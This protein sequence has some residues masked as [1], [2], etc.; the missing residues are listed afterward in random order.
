MG[1]SASI[2]T[3]CH[4]HRGTPLSI[5]EGDQLT[6]L[7]QWH[8]GRPVDGRRVDGSP[9]P[10]EA[11]LA[12]IAPV[13]AET[14]IIGGHQPVR[15]QR[16]DQLVEGGG[17]EIGPVGLGL[18]QRRGAGWPD[19]DQPQLAALI[20]GG[21]GRRAEG[22]PVDRIVQP[23]VD[24]VSPQ[25][26]WVV[27]RQSSSAVGAHPHVAGRGEGHRRRIIDGDGRHQLFALPGPDVDPIPPC[28]DHRQPVLGGRNR[29]RLD[30]GRTATTAAREVGPPQRCPAVV[31]A[32]VAK[33]SARWRGRGR[34]IPVAWP[35]SPGQPGR[36]EVRRQGVEVES[37]RADRRQFETGAVQAD[38]TVDVGRLPADQGIEQ[39]VPTGPG[40]AAHRRT[41]GSMGMISWPEG[42]TRA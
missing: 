23:R 1:T 33:D 8:H 10:I 2:R 34:Q 24:V 16:T 42:Q 36:R 19:G 30:R 15:R 7:D 17:N 14:S 4:W 3:R 41:S 12:T 35:T 5:R 38:E 25:A 29:N 6:L 18:P 32:G 31:A 27:H 21:T 40:S 39:P 20:G 11:P 22:Q 26:A 13:Q 9:V 37:V 28:V